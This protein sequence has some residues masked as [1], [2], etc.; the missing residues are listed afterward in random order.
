MKRV[1]NSNTYL[2][3]S[4]KTIYSRRE[5]KKCTKT[6]PILKNLEKMGKNIMRTGENVSE[7]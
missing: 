4:L 5:V 6:F 1:Y 7:T 2:N 3:L